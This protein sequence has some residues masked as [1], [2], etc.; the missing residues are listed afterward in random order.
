[1]RK[2]PA[3]LLAACCASSLI[4]KAIAEESKKAGGGFYGTLTPARPG[5]VVDIPLYDAPFNYERGGYTVP[6]MRQS[7]ALSTSYYEN[8]HRLIAGTRDEDQP[9]WRYAG[10]GAF[11]LISNYIPLGNAWMHEE[12]H[13]AVM[14][15]NDISS[16]N[17]VYTFPFF[18]DIIAVTNVS[19]TDLMRLK[20]DRKADM[21]RMSSAG[22]ESQVAQNLF[23][24]KHHF[25]DDSATFDQ[26]LLLMNAMTN[27]IYLGTCSSSA[28]N[29]VTRQQQIGEGRDIGARDFTGLDCNAWVYDLHRPDEPYTARG[30]HPSGL[31]INRYI[32]NS[33][34]T[35]RERRYLRKNFALSFL[36]FADPFLVGKDSFGGLNALGQEWRWNANLGHTLTSFGYTV[37]TRLFLRSGDEKYLLTLHNGFAQKYYPGLT[38]EMVDRPVGDGFFVTSA[39]TL[40]PQPTDQRLDAT[41]RQWLLDF[42]TQFS[43]QWTPLTFTY[44]GIQAKTPGWMMGDAYVDGNVSVWT[45]FR[46]ALF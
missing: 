44:F 2:F 39:L 29:T 31:G 16:Y 4:T 22:I 24:E 13:R 46:T 37:D 33:K 32:D 1:M 25:F 7:L 45:G 9:W 17:E 35:D 8:F 23:L 36:S 3:L 20:Q 34:L 11:D 28:A 5:T 42:M 27:V 26:P 15:R 10:V 6:S 18:Q 19:D 43:F 40:W 41:T 12:W 14:S 30:V 21:V 38:L